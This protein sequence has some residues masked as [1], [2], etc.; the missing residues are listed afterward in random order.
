MSIAYPINFSSVKAGNDKYIALFNFVS[1]D[2]LY[3]DRKDVTVVHY[4]VILYSNDEEMNTLRRFNTDIT[5]NNH[6]CTENDIGYY[7]SKVLGY[8]DNFG[9]IISKTDY[10]GE[11]RIPPNA[12]PASSI[13]YVRSIMA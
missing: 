3:R 4:H 13:R 11:L 1:L 10:V 7:M 2:L 12:L 5:I 8:S 6:R 9:R